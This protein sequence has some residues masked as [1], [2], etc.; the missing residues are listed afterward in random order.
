MLADQSSSLQMPSFFHGPFNSAKRKATKEGRRC[1]VQYQKDGSFPPPLELVA[2]PPGEV[3]VGRDVV[4]FDRARPAWRLYMLSD[5]MSGLC[6]ALDWKN[7]FQVSD[8]YEAAVRET[9]WG[10]LY[11]VISRNAPKS[12][13]RTALRLQAMLRFWEPLQSVRYLF[14]SPNVPMSLEQLMVD[15][16]NWAMDAW[17]PVGEGSVRERLERAA[18]RMAQATRDDCVDAIL[19]QMPRALAHANRL[20]HRTMLADPAFLRGRLATLGP[21]SFEH[22]SGAC[23]GELIA[24]L[25]DWDQQLGIQ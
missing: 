5:V 22:V 20:K 15:A 10:A 2:V 18:A 13:E 14:T 16:I 17:C 12:A 25:Y 11:F 9:A 4:D 8:A 23:T 6:E 24:Q 3:V 1:G 21:E 7:A 19:R